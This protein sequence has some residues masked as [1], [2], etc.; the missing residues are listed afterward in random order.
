MRR[1]HRRGTREHD[2][3]GTSMQDVHSTVQS[4]HRRDA[5]AP[6]LANPLAALFREHDAVGAGTHAVPAGGAPSALTMYDDGRRRIN[7]GSN[8]YLGLADKP[9]VVEAAVAALRRLGTSTA[10]SRVHNGTT[11]LRLTLEEELAAFYGAEAAVLAS[12]GINAN[13]ALLSTVCG[14]GDALLVDAHAHASVHG[15]A[16]ASAG[17]AIRFRHNDVGSLAARLGRLHPPAARGGGG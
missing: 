5:F 14:P 10:G 4:P 7:L 8:N 9:R 17:T 15:G 13:L 1:R 3:G 12:S 11:R 2:R 16:A 6:L